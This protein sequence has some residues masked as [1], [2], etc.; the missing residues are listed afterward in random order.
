DVVE[1]LLENRE[2]RARR[3][4]D[5]DVT[6][7]RRTPPAARGGALHEPAVAQDGGDCTGDLGRLPLAQHLGVRLVVVGLDPDDGAA[8]APPN[9]PPAGRRAGPG[10]EHRPDPALP[11]APP[12]GGVWELGARRRRP[13]PADRLTRLEEQADIGAAEAV[14]RLLRVADDEQPARL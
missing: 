10:H 3:E 4:E 7:L 8:P 6:G 13:P 1:P 5:G 11:P 12:G 14:D 2:R 9:V